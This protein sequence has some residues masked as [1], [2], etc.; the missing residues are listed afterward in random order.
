MIDIK[1]MLAKDGG[2]VSEKIYKINKRVFNGQFRLV[3][4]IFISTRNDI[5]V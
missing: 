3:F 1:W 5:N 2:D 4:K